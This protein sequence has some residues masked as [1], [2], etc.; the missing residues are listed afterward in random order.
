MKANQ[1][2]L[3]AALFTGLTSLSIAGPGSDYWAQQTKNAQEQKAKQ[4]QAKIQLKSDA[5]ATAPA[6]ACNQCS[7]CAGMQKT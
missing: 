7:G 1:L 4:E 3:A 5:P 6:T 2:F